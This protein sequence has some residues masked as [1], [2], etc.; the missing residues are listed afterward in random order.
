LLRAWH[1]RSLIAISLLPLALVFSLLSGVRRWLYRRGILPT[2]RLSV[3]VVVVGNISVGGVGKTPVVIHLAHALMQLGHRPGVISRGYRGSGSILEVGVDSDPGQVGDEPLLIQRQCACPVVVGADRVAAARALLAAH[4]DTSVILS[5]D[6]LQHYR[7]GRD[8]ELAVVNADGFG[9]RWLLPAGPLRERVGRLA[10]VDGVIGNGIA[11]PPAPTFGTPYFRLD[12]RLD[13]AYALNDEGR[14]RP[15]VD[16]IGLRLH[17]VAGIGSPQR[18][19]AQL[20]SL[21]LRFSA[22]E[23][24]DHHAYVADEL[25]FVGDALLTTEK[26]AVKFARLDF[27][28]PVWVVP[29]KVSIEPDLAQFVVEKL[30]GRAPA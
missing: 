9:N 26:D 11:V 10:Q 17:A 27:T 21:G 20:I 25:A 15:L 7:L 14:T 30:N 8:L 6:G 5:D 28:I 22:H 24:P 13:E 16:F 1:Q 12:S 19:F 18:F 4:P 2:H 23:F 29:L 3:P